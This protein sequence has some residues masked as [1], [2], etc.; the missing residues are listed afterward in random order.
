M[1]STEI[2]KKAFVEA[3]KSALGNVSKACEATGV[4]RGTFYR[5]KSEDADFADAISEVGEE[6]TDFAEDCLRKKM[7][8]GD[9]TAII[10]YLKTKGRERGY[11]ETREII[12]TAPVQV[13]DYGDE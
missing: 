13:I 9:T 11:T 12:S 3:Y 8:E 2:R 1:K 5:W 4:S 7:S 6:N 10:F